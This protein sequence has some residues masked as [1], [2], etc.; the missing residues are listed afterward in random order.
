MKQDCELDSTLGEQLGKCPYST[1]QSLI[2]G[3][4]ATLILYYLMDGPVRFNELE[5]RMPR[6]THAT[7]SSQLK[8]L[9]E[10]GLVERKQYESIPPVVEYSL[11][12]IGKRF[13]PV[14]D[15]MK[16][17]GIEYIDQMHKP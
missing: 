17:W 11:T 14:L 3:K 15:A 9:V 1:V 7:L 16:A 5:R 4:W 10:K 12:D 6:M 8:S 2:A 13:R